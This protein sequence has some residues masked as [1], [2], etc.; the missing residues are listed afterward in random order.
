[1]NCRRE[2][3]E[4]EGYEVGCSGVGGWLGEEGKWVALQ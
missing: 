1:M 4:K 2:I 3:E